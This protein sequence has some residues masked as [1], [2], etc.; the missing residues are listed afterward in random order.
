MEKNCTCTVK[1]TTHIDKRV[2]VEACLSHYGHR[3]SL[4]HIWL[5]KKKRE[6][7]VAKLKQGVSQQRI[8]DEIRD[9]VGSRLT[10]D[11]LIDKKDLANIRRSNFIDEVQRHPNDTTSVLSLIEKWSQS[12]R[13][14]VL[15]YK[16][17]GT[18]PFIHAK[19][20]VLLVFIYVTPIQK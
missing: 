16:L 9:N 19:Q 2:S 20:C 14:P 15:Y 18:I 6:E 11:H 3:R 12:E 17:Q 13:N 10:R 4:Q 8:L 5:S 7:L 1:V